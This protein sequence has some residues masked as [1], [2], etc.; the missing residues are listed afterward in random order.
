MVHKLRHQR[1]CHESAICHKGIFSDGGRYWLT[2]DG[3]KGHGFSINLSDCKTSVVGVHIK[4]VAHPYTKAA[5]RATRGFSVYG[6]LKDSGPWEKLLEEDFDNPL[7]DGAPEPSLQT[8]YFKEAVELQLLRF[9]LDSYWE[10][11]G[12]GLDFFAVITVSGHPFGILFHS[13]VFVCFKQ[14]CAN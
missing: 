9:D 13:D 7:L 14:I 8:F 10:T 2:K 11:K 5:A 6:A 1:R 12:G 4:N 3:Y